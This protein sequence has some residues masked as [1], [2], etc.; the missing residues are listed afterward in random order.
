MTNRPII[1]IKIQFDQ[2]VVIA[3]TRARQIADILGFDH[4]TQIAI[5]T[6]VSEI[7]RNAFNYA[8]NAFAE[9]SIEQKASQN[10]FMIKI[11]DQGNG[12]NYLDEILN[13][14]YN[15][16]TGLGKGIIG[17]KK[18]MDHFEIQTSEKG[19]I[20]HLGKIIPKSKENA[21]K[22]I[23]IIADKLIARDP[24]NIYEEVQMQNQELLKTLEEVKK[25]QEELT[26]MNKELEDTNRGV[27]A[28]YSELDQRAEYL[29][30]MSDVK[31]KFLSYMSHEFRT[32]VNSILALSKIL[33]DKIDGELSPEQETQVNFIKKSAEDLYDLVN[34]LLD[35]AKVESGK[36]EVKPEKFKIEQMFA[37]LRG[38]LKPL[39]N[40]SEVKLEFD[41]V[42]N[43]PELN[44]DEAKLSQILRNFISNAIKFTEKGE[45]K[46][47]VE[48]SENDDTITFCVS[49][50]GVGID[51]KFHSLIFE[52]FSQIDNRVQK[53][54]KGTGLGLP[55][56]KK[57]AELLGGE[58]WVE[59]ELNKGSKFF[60]KIPVDINPEKRNIK[61]TPEISG[62]DSKISIKKIFIIDDD[63]ISRYLVRGV[64]TGLPHD[65]YEFENGFDALGNIENNFPDLIMLDLVMPGLSGFDI[66]EKLSSDNLLSNIP[67]VVSTSM[68][69]NQT[70]IEKILQRAALIVSKDKLTESDVIKK[71]R[72]FL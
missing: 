56:S 24:V 39:L 37:S 28:L 8:K 31:A 35:M 65:I 21:V 30:N 66:L 49:D 40:K 50:T 46:V 12:I 29:K 59:S 63:E 72:S 71:I 57:M 4:K 17:S 2:D 61:K 45:V 25:R 41:E 55:L 58:V 26:L 23:S 32:P 14:N 20:V 67:V 42:K 15:S 27:L 10:L 69:L 62:T 36:I 64:F 9:Y 5:A 18:L 34:D 48:F 43:L 51:P 7:A 47:D 38:L 1:T 13:G 53:K 3:R 52:E 19:T 44:T 70:E 11:K 60:V 33:L 16:Q 54:V 68:E 6:A 22:D